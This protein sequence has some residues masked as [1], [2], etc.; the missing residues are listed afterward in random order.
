MTSTVKNTKALYLSF[1]QFSL[2][3]KLAME[4]L[5]QG[6]GL[7]L[8]RI[9]AYLIY[10]FQ[11]IS[12]PLYFTVQYLEDQTFGPIIV[13]KA[14][15]KAF[16]WGELFDFTSFSWFTASIFILFQIYTW[17]TMISFGL[18]IFFLFKGMKVGT[19]FGYLW[20][21]VCYV[22]PLVLGFPIFSFHLKLCYF[23]THEQISLLSLGNESYAQEI[24]G[25]IFSVLAIIWTLLFTILSLI[26]SSNSIKIKDPLTAKS[27]LNLCLGFIEKVLLYLIFQ[28]FPK[29]HSKIW[30]ILLLNFIL[31]LIRFIHTYFTFPFYKIRVMQT[32]MVFCSLQLLLVAVNLFGWLLC[33]GDPMITQRLLFLTWVLLIPIVTKIASSTFQKRLTYI[34]ENHKDLSPEFIIHKVYITKSVHDK[35]SPC[36]KRK[37]TFNFFELFFAGSSHLLTPVDLKTQQ[38]VKLDLDDPSHFRSYAK[39]LLRNAIL[40]HPKA[41]S[42]RITYIDI[43][44]KYTENY[45]ESAYLLE[46]LMSEHNSLSTE[47]SILLLKQKLEQYLEKRDRELVESSKIDMAGYIKLN[48]KYEELKQ[49]ILDQSKLHIQFWEANLS[50]EFDFRVITDL[51][52]KIQHC[53]SDISRFWK[54]L[55]GINN[56]NF[57]TPYLAYGLYLEA[58][59]NMPSSSLKFIT[60]QL[61][62]LT[63]L[64]VDNNLKELCDETLYHSDN[65]HLVVSGMKED[66]GTI[67]E[68]SPSSLKTLGY[69]RLGLIGKNVSEIMPESINPFLS[70]HLIKF[71][72]G[73]EPLKKTNTLNSCKVE[74]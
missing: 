31:A 74:N 65:V 25:I 29:S 33:L 43:L 32:E 10:V 8:A 54:E 14:I 13:L 28:L 34:L 45:H 4:F 30:G 67:L 51:S 38:K 46:Q 7:R 72:F 66:L 52:L 17:M 60:Q 57:M 39:S 37:K 56:K 48:E 71:P 5:P 62:N 9:V 55:E 24:L 61:T 20:S 53:Q 6:K 58:L 26:F 42:L 3:A 19:L 70:R 1:S 59:N 21:V 22:H 27:K 2:F 40:A 73:F 44:L 15:C 63:R 50:S 12:I 16:I 47:I 35:R 41:K 49:K 18:L 68:C 23:F 11:L 36:K 69:D 64:E